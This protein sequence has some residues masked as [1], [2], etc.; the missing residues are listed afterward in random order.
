MKVIEYPVI[1]AA[2]DLAALATF[3]SPGVPCRG[4]ISVAFWL[5]ATNANVP[6]AAYVIEV[7]KAP[8]GNVAGGGWITA[9]V[10]TTAGCAVTGVVPTP[11]AL[12]AGGQV[13][14]VHNSLVAGPANPGPIVLWDEAR[15]TVTGHATL[16]IAGLACRAQVIFPEA[17]GVHIDSSVAS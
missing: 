17:G 11:A 12:N 14:W 8:L 9:A 6:G 3:T 1:R 5:S 16:V 2:A 7:R 4:A 15:I 10:A 13:C